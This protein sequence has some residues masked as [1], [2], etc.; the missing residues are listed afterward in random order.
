MGAPKKAGIRSVGVA[1]RPEDAAAVRRARRL[2]AWLEKRGV[3]VLAH[4][5]WASEHGRLR[6]VD[7]LTMMREADLVVVLGGDGSLLGMA[8]LSSARAAPVVGIHHGDFGFL[9]D[10]EGDGPYE[11][12]KKILAGD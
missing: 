10:V 6:C 3:E 11:T 1:V 2:A 5:Q 7:R 12:M 8:R 9:T 4:E